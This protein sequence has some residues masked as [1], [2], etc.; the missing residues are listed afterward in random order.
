M[1]SRQSLILESFLKLSYLHIDQACS[2]CF[3]KASGAFKGRWFQ[4]HRALV[5]VAGIQNGAWWAFFNSEAQMI[6]G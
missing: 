3:Q 2:L 4:Y 6:V 5:S 1:E